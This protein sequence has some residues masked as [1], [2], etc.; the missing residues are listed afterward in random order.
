[1]LLTRHPCGGWLGFPCQPPWGGEA[2]AVGDAV[3][4]LLI[5]PGTELR[6]AQGAG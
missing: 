3:M 5:H 2:A 4:L 1:M 6:C